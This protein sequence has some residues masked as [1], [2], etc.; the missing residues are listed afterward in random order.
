MA[1]ALQD[2]AYKRVI[3]LKINMLTTQLNYVPLNAVVALLRIHLI[4]YV[5]QYARAHFLLTHQ[6]IYVQNIVQTP[7]T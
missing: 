7:V 6:L 3:A 4:K 1:T 5:Y 2:L